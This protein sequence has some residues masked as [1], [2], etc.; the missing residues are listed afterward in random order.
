MIATKACAFTGD[1][2]AEL[3]RFGSFEQRHDLEAQRVVV[4]DAVLRPTG[5]TI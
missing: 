4:D 2:K 5:A 1:E 3:V